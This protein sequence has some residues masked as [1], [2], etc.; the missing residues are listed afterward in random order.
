MSEM[1]ELNTERNF[2]QRFG[3]V[4]TFLGQEFL[5][6][7]RYLAVFLVPL[8]ILFLAATYYY[9]VYAGSQLILMLG[10]YVLIQLVVTFTYAY[11]KS[12]HE[13]D[14]I[15]LKSILYQFPSTMYDLVVYY[16]IQAVVF[17]YYVIFYFFNI[18]LNLELYTVIIILTSCTSF[19][20]LYIPAIKCFSGSSDGNS[21]I[22]SFRMIKKYFFPTLFANIIF[23]IFRIIEFPPFFHSLFFPNLIKHTYTNNELREGE[24]ALIQVNQFFNGFINF[25]VPGLFISLFCAF[26]Y[27]SHKA[28]ENGGI[29]ESE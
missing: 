11:L 3:L 10:Y 5:R 17:F 8:T 7:F 24:M 18:D 16:V 15:T 2:I 21:F 9:I 27:L 4:F 29:T 13:D 22:E 14:S 25:I 19:I 26:T 20:I 6:F 23:D 1:I 12:Y 28:K